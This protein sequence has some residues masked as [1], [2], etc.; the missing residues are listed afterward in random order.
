VPLKLKVLTLSSLSASD[1]I[2]ILPSSDPVPNWFGGA[3]KQLSFSSNHVVVVVELIL[4]RRSF[5]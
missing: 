4:K 5:F 1:K 2:E 3:L